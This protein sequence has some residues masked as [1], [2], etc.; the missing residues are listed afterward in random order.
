M[1]TKEEI[2]KKLDQMQMVMLA[3]TDGEKAYVRPVMMVFFEQRFFIATGTEDNKWAQLEKRKTA[4]ICYYTN[5]EE[6]GQYIRINGDVEFVE[7]LE[8]RS[9]I[10]DI[11]EFIKYYWTDPSDPGFGLI[12]IIPDYVAFMPYNKNLEEIIEFK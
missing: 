2:I 3:T 7:E 10:M 8:L 12:E 9:R 11:A 5:S 1:I 4:E 6:K